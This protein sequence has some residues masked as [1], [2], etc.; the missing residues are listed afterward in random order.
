MTYCMWHTYI[1][2]RTQKHHVYQPTMFSQ[3]RCTCLSGCKSWFKC[4]TQD[5]M[6]TTELRNGFQFSFHCPAHFCQPT[7]SNSLP[8]CVRFDQWEAPEIPAAELSTQGRLYDRGKNLQMNLRRKTIEDF[9]KEGDF[10]TG[11]FS[12]WFELNLNMLVGKE[13]GD[14]G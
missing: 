12:G 6:K 13:F 14:V 11:Y 2:T 10:V 7:S 1:I 4:I 3:S 9:I 5:I 8:A